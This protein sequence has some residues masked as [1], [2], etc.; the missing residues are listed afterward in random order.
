LADQ[1]EIDRDALDRLLHQVEIARFAR[2]SAAAPG[3]DGVADA[4]SLLEALRAGSPGPTRWRARL[5]PRSLGPRPA[6]HSAEI[7][8]ATLELG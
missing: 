8:P 4:H 6:V 2:P 7:A 5:L 3:R 1:R